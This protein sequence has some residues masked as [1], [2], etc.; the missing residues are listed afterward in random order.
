MGSVSGSTSEDDFRPVYNKR[1]IVVGVGTQRSFEEPVETRLVDSKSSISNNSQQHQEGSGVQMLPT[2]T[3]Q[4]REGTLE[5]SSG[6]SKSG[7]DL[8]V[9]TKET[10][11]NSLKN[12]N[13]N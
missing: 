3:G 12:S 11:Y 9:N 8:P 1:S 13:E 5:F 2:H 10:I 7:E 6:I 4:T